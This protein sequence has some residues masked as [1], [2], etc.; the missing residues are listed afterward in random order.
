M[1][2]MEASAKSAFNVD[3]AFIESAKQI[4][5]RIEN[6]EYDL[7]SESC[8]IKIGNANYQDKGLRRGGSGGRQN[9]SC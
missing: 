7:S 1:L 6:H 4:L 9:C 2:F 8:G 3:E 5:G